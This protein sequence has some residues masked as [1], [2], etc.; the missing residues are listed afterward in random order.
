[1]AVRSRQQ[2]VEK[3]LKDMGASEDIVM[4]DENRNG[5]M[6]NAYRT[7]GEYKN[8]PSDVTHMC[9]IS[10]DAEIVNNFCEI[11]DECV[12][13]FPDVI[14]TFY[15][16]EL[17][18]KKKPIDTPYVKLLSYNI[19]GIAFL[20]PIG[21]VQGYLDFYDKYLRR[22]DYPRDDATCR[23]YALMKDIPVMTTIPNLV[24]SYEIP[25][26]MKTHGITHNSDCWQGVNID[27]EQF[28]QNK[29]QCVSCAKKSAL[30]T[31]LPKGNDFD[32]VIKMVYEKRKKAWK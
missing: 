11:V 10:D 16:N 19:R 14:W 18:Y 28:R 2:Y 22:Y 4:W 26:E 13:R 5:C 29:Y 17:S 3:L 24:R 32:P 31:H 6:W 8:L 15:S 7:W 12:N 30:E 27:V 1:M 9:V 25:S 23:I 20:M 21:L